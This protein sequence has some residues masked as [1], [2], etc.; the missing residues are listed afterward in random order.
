MHEQQTRQTIM[1]DTVESGLIA[2]AKRFTLS[3]LSGKN[4]KPHG[5][6]SA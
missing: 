6:L 2:S 3:H 1:T 5:C 4:Q